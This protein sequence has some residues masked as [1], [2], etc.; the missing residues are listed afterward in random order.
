[1]DFLFTV[2]N[3]FIPQLAAS[4]CSICKNNLSAKSLHFYILADKV[5]SENKNKLTNFITEQDRDVHFIDISGFI[6]TFDDEF[7]TLGWNEVI[8]AR[9]LMSRFIPSEVHKIIYLDGD[10]I[11]RNSLEDLWNTDLGGNILAAAM[12]PTVDAKRRCS[13]G[14]EDLPYFNSGV[15]LVDL[16]KWREQNAEQLI[17]NYCINH[18]EKLFAPDQDAINAALS[19]SIAPLSPKYNFCNII[20][21]YPYSMM[22]KLMNCYVDESVYNEAKVNPFII[23]YLGEERPWR[24]G[25][26]HEYRDDYVHYLSMTPWAN[27]PMESGW[28]LYFF[29]WNIFNS[30]TKHAPMLRYRIINGLIPAFMKI[31]KRARNRQH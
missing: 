16:D 29:A 7:D 8:M 11:V 26:K 27:T 17:L 20:S 31:R 28:E 2:D 18:K 12:E 23:H 1:M 22:K 15:L 13:L 6:R 21:I 24:K 10:T 25:N 19:N 30:I 5:S 4:I 14:L 3:N 9:I